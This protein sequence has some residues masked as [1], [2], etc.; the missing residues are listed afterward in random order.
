MDG[1][2]FGEVVP[3]GIGVGYSVQQNRLRYSVTSRHPN[4]KW[5][6]RVCQGLEDSLSLMASLFDEKE[7]KPSLQNVKPNSQ[8]VKSKL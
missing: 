6:A 3:D 4:E 1:W 8:N 5:A 2:A 7:G